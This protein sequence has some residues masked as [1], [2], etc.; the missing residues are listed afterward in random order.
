[1][2]T[3]TGDIRHFTCPKCGSKDVRATVFAGYRQNEDGSWDIPWIEETDD[4][5]LVICQLCEHEGTYDDFD[6]EALLK[7]EEAV[8]EHHEYTVR[9]TITFERVAVVQAQNE[10]EALD[11]AD[12]AIS[13]GEYTETQVDNTPWDVT[14]GDDDA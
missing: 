9:D 11:K 12:A 6:T 5:G 3:M 2:S 7:A 14:G 8:Q 4:E 13:A 10:D 1:M